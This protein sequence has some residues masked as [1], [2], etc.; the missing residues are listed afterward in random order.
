MEPI[1]RRA[2][3][4]NRENKEVIYIFS[5][6]LLLITFYAGDLPQGKYNSFEHNTKIAILFLKI[7]ALYWIASALVHENSSS[8]FLASSAYSVGL[9]YGEIQTP[10]FQA[11]Y[12]HCL[13][14]A[15]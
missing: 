1:F 4:F 7:P 12:F 11:S 3:I 15:T 10:Y 5:N 6:T 8:H 2:N 14:T 13:P 9:H